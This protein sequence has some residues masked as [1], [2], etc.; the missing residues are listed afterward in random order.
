M[1]VL[2]TVGLSEIGGGEYAKTKC[3]ERNQVEMKGLA[4]EFALRVKG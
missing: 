4:R 3:K 1:H 2:E